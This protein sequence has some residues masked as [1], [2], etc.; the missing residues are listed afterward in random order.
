MNALSP[1]RVSSEGFQKTG[2]KLSQVVA[3]MLMVAKAL[4]A[5]ALLI[6]DGGQTALFV[7]FETKHCFP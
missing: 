3:P 5:T 7:S 6:K 2:R 1:P 4:Q